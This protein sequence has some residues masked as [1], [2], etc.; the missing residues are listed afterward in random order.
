MDGPGF[1]SMDVSDGT[2]QPKLEFTVFVPSADFFAT[3]R[4]NQAS[5]DLAKKFNVATTDNGSGGSGSGGGG[6][7][8]RGGGGGRGGGGRGGG[9]GGGDH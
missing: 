1:D 7:G 5:L 8:D 3:M 9:G 2:K 6:G 4:R